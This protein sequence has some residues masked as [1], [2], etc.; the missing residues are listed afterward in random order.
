MSVATIE[1]S[2]P[3]MHCAGCAA[4]VTRALEATP[5]ASDVSVSAISQSAR[6]N[7][8]GDPHTV[9]QALQE[10]G[11][12]PEL[13][14][15][16][17][18]VPSM[19]CGSCVARVEKAV[20]EAPEVLDARAMLTDHSL[21]VTLTSPAAA[22]E[23]ARLAARAGYPV[24]ARPAGTLTAT[25]RD[26]ARALLAG[27]LTLPVFLAEMGGHLWAPLHHT[28][29]S[30]GAVPFWAAQLVLIGAVLAGPGRGLMVN[31][32]RRL[33]RRSPDMDSLVALGAG[34]AFLYSTLVLLAPT[35]FPD[36]ARAVYFEAAGVIVTLI[37][38]GRWL[39]ARAKTRSDSAIRALVGLQPD[40]APVWREGQFVETDLADVAP[41]DRLL[42][43]Q[44]ARVAVDGE[45]IEGT[46]A[47][48]EAMLTG[49]PLP[50][51]KTPGDILS[52]G[53]VNA[54]GVLTYRAT[55]VGADTALA[56]ITAMVRAAQ[57]LRLP[58][59]ALVD[60]IA[61]WFVPAVLAL[62]TLTVMV[63]LL[64]GGAVNQALV[65]GVSVLIIACPCAMGLATPVSIVVGVG[66]AA[67]QGI[68]FRQG[69]ALQTVGDLDIV[70]FDK[71]GTLTAGKPVMTDI[72]LG[73]GISRHEALAIAAAV[74][75][76][77]THPLAQALVAAA[78]AAYT[79]AT[80][81][82]ETA[83]QGAEALVN[84]RKVLIGKR[85]LL[86]L[87][88]VATDM[89]NPPGSVTASLVYM[90]V[91][92]ALS[93]IFAFEDPVKPE[94]APAIAALRT[95]GIQTLML[96][97]DRAEAA[98]AVGASLGMDRVEAA[99]SP[100]EK[101]SHIHALQKQGHHVGFVG[102]G[103]NDA[104]ALAAADVG[105]A[106]GTGTDVAIGA[107]DVV[108]MSGDP[109]RVASA[110]FLSRRVMTNIRQNLFWAFGYNVALIP[111]AA[112]VLYPVTGTLL[113]PMLAA[114]AMALSSL[115]VLANA[116]RLRHAGGIA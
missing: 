8:K 33:L 79:P 96:S 103:I 99:L 29:M 63:W 32:V 97:G 18:H 49:E 83:G 98:D 41:G 69:A 73:P 59:Q 62:A 42:L 105:F 4:K 94:A 60:R 86:A 43:P 64:L 65:A 21:H 38:T 15:L 10:V 44:G 50:V 61:L 115:F 23:V 104:P 11:Y 68:L 36:T 51:T 7:V 57:A 13:T 48:D 40:T 2:I 80:D 70:A 16:Q 12:P 78:P 108:L 45:V 91:D 95:Q 106:I 47:V 26:G 100:A 22:A 74:E 52:A 76:G 19:S 87:H 84:G 27:L 56:R 66:R 25:P 1:L 102:D 109:G 75:A 101:L 37:L 107:A 113:S 90:A 92:E 110:L 6:L 14:E 116:L 3:A 53:T 24:T 72:A 82:R 34:A 30:L 114:G 31:G 55:A 35:L 39:E 58:V 93:A 112:G 111:V 77:S 5:G 9:L 17:F 20:A 46:G 81:I 54:G 28:L 67:G 71:T 85:D 88:G 89:L